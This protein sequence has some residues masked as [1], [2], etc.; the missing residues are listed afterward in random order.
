MGPVVVLHVGNNDVATSPQ[1]SSNSPKR[2]NFL[3]SSMEVLRHSRI[4]ITPGHSPEGKVWGSTKRYLGDFGEV[5]VA[6]IDSILA[7]QG[8]KAHGF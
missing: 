7:K 8:N 4:L 6:R 3:P 2:R 1:T 5:T